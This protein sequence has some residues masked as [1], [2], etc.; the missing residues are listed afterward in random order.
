MKSN[1]P[2]ALSLQHPAARYCSSRK[3]MPPRSA[4]TAATAVGL[5]LPN[6]SLGKN[7]LKYT[8]SGGSKNRGFIINGALGG[9]QATLYASGTGA[10]SFTTTVGN[11]ATL[12]GSGSIGGSVT[13]QNVVTFAAGKSIESLAT[14]ALSLDAGSTFVYEINKDAAAAVAGD[15]TA[16]TTIPEPRAALLGG[17]GLLML[18]RR[19]RND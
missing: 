5:R 6:G 12:R 8:G 15:L 13:V 18:L 2:S 10:V 14:G 1:T 11:T 7:T 4:G 19:R 16:V 3:N 17:L 9:N